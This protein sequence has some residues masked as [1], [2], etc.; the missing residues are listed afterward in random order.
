MRAG[1]R[2]VLALA[3]V[4]GGAFLGS[5]TFARGSEPLDDRLGVRVAPVF[6]LIR[7]DIQ[8]DLGLEPGEIAEANRFAAVIYSKAL[9]LKGKV[10]PEVVAA[11]RAI[12]EEESD[13]MSSHLKAEQRERLGQIDLQWEGASAVLNRRAVAE[14]L[15]LTSDQHDQ[16]ARVYGDA[17]RER[18]KQGPWNYEEHLEMTRKAIAVLSAKQ[19]QLWVKVLGPPCR[20]VIAT[21]PPAPASGGQKP[22]DSSANGR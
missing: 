5:T 9:S 22:G 16:V 15:G 18:V 8:K 17:K 10:G 13:W 14:Y 4:G 12:D 3:I 1:R 6:L 19:K 20:F 21:V 2:I 11:R 7:S